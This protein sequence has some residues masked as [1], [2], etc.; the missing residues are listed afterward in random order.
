MPERRTTYEYDDNGCLAASTEYVESEWDE[1]QQAIMLAYYAWESTRCPAC[2]GNP[3]ECQGADNEFAWKADGPHRCH[4][5]AT[6]SRA[7]RE[8]LKG[9]PDEVADSLMFQ[10]EHRG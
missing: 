4:R 9:K 10:M 2:G 8:F 7:Q 1:E 6:R 5:T 3:A